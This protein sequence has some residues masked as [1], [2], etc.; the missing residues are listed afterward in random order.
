MHISE[1]RTLTLVKIYSNI[2][3]HKY[4]L[5]IA[6]NVKVFEDSGMAYFDIRRCDNRGKS[7][8]FYSSKEDANKVVKTFINSKKLQWETIKQFISV[9]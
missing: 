3:L 7:I 5:D 6:V 1:L 2:E 8:T 4:G 9:K